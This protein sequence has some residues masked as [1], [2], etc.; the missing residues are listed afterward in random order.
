MG[1]RD[2]PGNET[3]FSVGSLREAFASVFPLSGDPALNAPARRVKSRA[4]DQRCRTI[5][6]LP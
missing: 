4:K 5:F 6:N 2:A 1:H 3:P